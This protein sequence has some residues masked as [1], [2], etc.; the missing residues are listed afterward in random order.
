MK[1]NIHNDLL[2]LLTYQYY[3]KQGIFHRWN[4]NDNKISGL[5]LPFIDQ[6]K[7]KL[8]ISC[9]WTNGKQKRTLGSKY[10][11]NRILIFTIHFFTK[12]STKIH[13]KR[14]WMKIL[15]KYGVKS[16]IWIQKDFGTIVR[17]QIQTVKHCTQG[18]LQKA[19]YSC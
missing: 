6:P 2:W 7:C 16:K 18:G 9:K 14:D 12:Y 17:Q 19:Y 8:H 1:P 4:I 5:D 11:W 3:E 13:Y 15:T 10:S